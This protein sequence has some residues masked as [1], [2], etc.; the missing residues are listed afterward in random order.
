MLQLGEII[1]FVDSLI[2]HQF[3]KCLFSNGIPIKNKYCLEIY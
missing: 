1:E 3:L 2:N